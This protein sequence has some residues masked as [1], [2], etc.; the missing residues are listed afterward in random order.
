MA[1]RK[2]VVGDKTYKYVIG[3]SI[4]KINGV[5]IFNTPENGEPVTPGAIRRVIEG[6]FT[7]EPQDGG[8]FLFNRPQ[9]TG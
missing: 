1:Y 8:G 7:K 4:I 5:G 3:K 6:G 9:I 2:I